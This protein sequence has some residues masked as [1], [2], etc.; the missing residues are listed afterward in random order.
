LGFSN[1]IQ[2]DLGD[3]NNDKK[4]DAVVVNVKLDNKVSPPA[5][6]SCPVEI[7]INNL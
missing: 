6:V 4:I 3:I 2:V 1:S 7:W 5:S